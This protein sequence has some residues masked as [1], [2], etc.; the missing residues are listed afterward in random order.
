MESEIDVWIVVPDDDLFEDGSVQKKG[1][2]GCEPFES[3]PMH[4]DSG[5]IVLLFGFD[6]TKFSLFEFEKTEST[7]GPIGKCCDGQGRMVLPKERYWS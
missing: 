4:E 2:S 3:L 7:I 5:E 6:F 1:E